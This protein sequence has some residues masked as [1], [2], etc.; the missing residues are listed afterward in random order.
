MRI[1][2]GACP[3]GNRVKQRLIGDRIDFTVSPR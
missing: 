1:V 3:A 2:Q